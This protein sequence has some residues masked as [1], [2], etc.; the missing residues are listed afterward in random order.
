MRTFFPSSFN[1]IWEGKKTSEVDKIQ[2]PSSN[3]NKFC[4]VTRKLTTEY[5]FTCVCSLSP[6]FRKKCR[7]AQTQGAALRRTEG[8]RDYR[9][10]SSHLKCVSVREL[11]P[12]SFAF[13][14]MIGHVEFLDMDSE[15]GFSSTSGRTQ[16][17]SKYRLITSC[18]GKIFL[19]WETTH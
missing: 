14:R 17:A 5:L 12:T 8:S 19:R 18:K 3:A 13:Q 6:Q 9:F 15:I 16:L 7:Q 1:E 2:K 4:G 10:T 11:L